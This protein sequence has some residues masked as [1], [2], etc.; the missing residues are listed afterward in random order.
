MRD[1]LTTRDYGQGMVC[2][3]LSTELPNMVFSNPEPAYLSSRG[4]YWSQQ[5][6]EIAPECI[7]KPRSAD[8]VSKVI[9]V[10][11]PFHDPAVRSTSLKFAVR[12][13]GHS[14][15]AGFSTIQQGV[16][17]D[18]SFINEVS[19]SEDE[20]S[21]VIGTGARW[22]D[23]STKLDSMN[24]AVAGG[25][26][27]KVGVGGLL[28]GGGISFFSP[29]VGLACDNI[30]EYEV[31][32]ANGTVMNATPSSNRDLWLALKGGSNNFGIVTRLVTRTFTQGKIWGGYL[33]QPIWK[34]PQ[35]IE[36]FQRF[37][38]MTEYD[39]YAAGPIFAV[40]YKSQIRTTAIA[41]FIIYTKPQKFP[42][43]FKPFTSIFRLWS[44]LKV[45][46]ISDAT[47]EL[48]AMAPTGLRQFQVTTTIQNDL[49][50]L[51][52]ASDLYRSSN[53]KLKHVK[54]LTSSIVFQPLPPAITS[55]SR[56]N[57]LGISS[58]DKTLIIVLVNASWDKAEDDAV[59][60]SVTRSLIDEINAVALSRGVADRYRYLNYAAS[61]QY[62]IAGY[63]EDNK[64]F[65]EETSR[66][67]D[68][69]GLFQTSCVGGFKIFP[70]GT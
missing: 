46:T 26:D 67:Y 34:A 51:K 12:S 60:E 62:V 24:L 50:T 45:R 11:G 41:N 32:L 9:Q 52:A 39:E 35:A 55:K 31:V 58:R 15:E 64:R 22:L 10:I 16:V 28:L 23:V 20:K 1:A 59:L 19:V 13:G 36:A 14:P 49:A 54:G 42:E 44:T 56:D 25:R 48:D 18:L 29:R 4:S 66:K 43:C 33:Y 40:G 37:G 47:Q 5:A 68:P 30:I 57:I 53:N 38:D 17:V 63:G 61:R 6:S 8:D 65:L 3:A 21:V 7:V 2:E 69:R 27:S 70:S